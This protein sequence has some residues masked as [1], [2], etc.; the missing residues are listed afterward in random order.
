MWRTPQAHN[1]LQG[2]K[3]LEF[4]EQCQRTNQSSITLTDQVRHADMWPTPQAHDSH[5]GDAKRVGRH[6]TKHGGRDL[7]DYV[8]LWPTPHAQSHTGIG[9]HGNGGPN[10]QTAVALWSTPAAQDAK[11]ATLPPSQPEH[12]T[13][14]GDMIRSGATGQLNP[15]WVENLQGLPIGWTDADAEETESERLRQQP[16]WPAFMGQEQHPHEPPRVAKGV[17]NRVAR[18]KALGNIVVPAQAYPIFAAI[19]EQE[20]TKGAN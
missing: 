16:P 4:Y 17:K 18:L 1:A 9:E 11:N 6:G 20:R 13:L 19:A 14:P 3:S 8:Q 7:A 12:D 5:G 2:P 10:I 15:A